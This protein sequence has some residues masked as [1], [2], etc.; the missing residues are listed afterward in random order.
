MK[1]IDIGGEKTLVKNGKKV[2]FTISILKQVLQHG[3]F[4]THITFSC[5]KSLASDLES[6][7]TL[8]RILCPNVRS[9]HFGYKVPLTSPSAYYLA[10]NYF[11]L[12]SFVV[13]N[14]VPVAIFDDYEDSLARIFVNNKLQHVEIA[15]CNEIRGMCFYSLRGEYLESFKIVRCDSVNSHMVYE[16]STIPL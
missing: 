2:D 6:V 3:T 15:C 12:T 9:L 8:T 10:W 13:K 5:I 4:L 11:K 14:F 16:V 1:K 7:L